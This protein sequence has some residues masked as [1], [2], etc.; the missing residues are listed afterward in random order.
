MKIDF[1]F[2]FH[3]FSFPLFHY[4]HHWHHHH[5]LFILNFK[6]NQCVEAFLSSTSQIENGNKLKKDDQSR[7]LLLKVTD[8]IWLI[9]TIFGWILWASNKI[10]LINLFMF[11]KWIFVYSKNFL[12]KIVY[13][14]DDFMIVA[15]RLGTIS[16]L[17]FTGKMEN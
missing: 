1:E 15:S 10:P 3:I 2:S 7:I 6:K 9:Y 16:S 8:S 12:I 14:H 4:L 5:M 17:F 11:Q 13:V